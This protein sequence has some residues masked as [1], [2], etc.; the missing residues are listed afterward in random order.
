M[1]MTATKAIII[2]NRQGMRRGGERGL[3]GRAPSQPNSRVSARATPARV[4]D[5]GTVMA[6]PSLR[7]ARRAVEP[8]NTAFTRWA[9]VARLGG[10][11]RREV[12]LE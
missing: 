4:S 9:A 3:A 7:P 8:P 1:A 11:G 2:M 6:A 10:F 5:M 12:R